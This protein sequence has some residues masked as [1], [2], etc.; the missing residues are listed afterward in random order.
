MIEH[1]LNQTIRYQQTINKLEIVIK[2]LRQQLAQAHE[3]MPCGHPRACI[4][5]GDE[6]TNHCSACVQEQRL[7]ALLAP[8]MRMLDEH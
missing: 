2:T 7:I 5:S 4:V 8:S 3:I 6:G 1:D